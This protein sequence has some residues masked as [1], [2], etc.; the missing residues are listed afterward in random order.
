MNIF[1]DYVFVCVSHLT[2]A[3]AHDVATASAAVGLAVQRQ[4]Y[5]HHGRR[6]LQ[7]TGRLLVLAGSVETS[8][9]FVKYTQFHL[10][11]HETT[12]A[13]ALL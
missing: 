13:W 8:L 1:L 10:A 6:V 5:E 12:S 9:S 2:A 3:P 7:R 4:V 11:I